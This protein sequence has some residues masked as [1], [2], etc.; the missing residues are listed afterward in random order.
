MPQPSSPS[1]P[2][3]ATVD[4]SIVALLRPP[5]HSPAVPGRVEPVDPRRP[6]LEHFTSDSSLA[7][8]SAA[9]IESAS[10]ADTSIYS[11]SSP[12]S[13]TGPVLTPASLPF[14]VPSASMAP[15]A[16][17]SATVAVAAT[18]GAVGGTGG[19]PGGAASPSSTMSTSSSPP[20]H[21]FPTFL[22]SLLTAIESDPASIRAHLDNLAGCRAAPATFAALPEG[23][24]L[25]TDAIIQSLTRIADRLK[26]KEED[27]EGESISDVE[28]DGGVDGGPAASA[29]VHE[30]QTP[31]AA[32]PVLLNSSNG[33]RTPR[34]QPLPPPSQSP[35]RPR[36]RSRPTTG[37]VTARRPLVPGDTLEDVRRNYED[38]LQALKVLHAEELYRAQ[39]SH[40]NEV[41]SVRAPP[42]VDPSAAA[43]LTS[44]VSGK[45]GP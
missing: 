34:D 31:S 37:D 43:G 41:R 20:L 21:S 32:F 35:S 25:E 27:E 11:A 4:P 24:P 6:A 42:P 23:K 45:T 40:D 17:E 44:G 13:A 39:V 8:S 14:S 36:H 22:L 19:A 1:L 9:S 28:K 3:P 7:S 16:F 12:S 38:Q 5:A 2:H 18:K 33:T 10:T 29:A 26:E 15:A 30:V